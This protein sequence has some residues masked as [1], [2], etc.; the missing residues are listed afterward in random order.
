MGWTKRQLCDMAFNEIALAGYNFDIQPEEMVAMV[1]RLDSMMAT[2]EMYGIRIGYNRTVSPKAADPDQD[3]G[4]PD[5]ANETVYLNL[6]L[7]AAPSYGKQIA[8]PTAAAAKQSYD[9][10]LGKCLASPPQMQLRGKVP[11][12]AG[13]KRRR[14][15]N[16]FLLNPVDVLT[17]G[18][19]GTLD[20]NGPVP[21]P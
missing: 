16:P 20:F 21:L 14:C 5:Q 13:Y 12:G 15:N 4:I 1:Q 10:L 6:A 17:T 2:W 19:D 18:P 3:S 11:A 9:A 7:R 8:L